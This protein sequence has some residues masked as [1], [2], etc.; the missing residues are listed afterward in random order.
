MNSYVHATQ[1][2]NAPDAL[3]AVNSTRINDLKTAYNGKGQY[4]KNLNADNITA[5]KIAAQYVHADVYNGT[6]V[7]ATNIK[8]GM[9][10][11]DHINTRTFTGENAIFD[12][13]VYGG[14]LT[15]A[16]VRTG[17][18]GARAEMREDGYKFAAYNAQNKPTFYVDAN[19]NVVMNS[20]S[21]SSDV[22]SEASRNSNIVTWIGTAGKGGNMQFTDNLALQN[23][24]TYFPITNN[25]YTSGKNGTLNVQYCAA[26]GY[27]FQDEKSAVGAA[28]PAQKTLPADAAP[29]VYFVDASNTTKGAV[30][31][32]T[33][34]YTTQALMVLLRLSQTQAVR[35][36][37]V[38]HTLTSTLI[39][40]QHALTWLRVRTL[41]VT[42][43]VST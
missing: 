28:A 6:L 30:I 17:S 32:M 37:G 2:Y 38:R 40:L 18:T 29:T 9:L 5:G 4:I 31:R 20:G 24:V 23:D 43:C 25:Y 26:N 14:I 15:G 33:I 11:A 22:L 35:K 34:K 16:V 27:L 41:R 8:A 1:P 21:I 10:D 12:A 36:G 42:S 7:N 13:E 39:T 19:G 3:T